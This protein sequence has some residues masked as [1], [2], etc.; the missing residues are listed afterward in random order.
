MNW[1]VKR[2]HTA[3]PSATY[4]ELCDFLRCSGSTLTTTEAIVR[5]LQH[6]MEA[7]RATVSPLQGFQWRFR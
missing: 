7:Q 3:V 4:S 5:A 1:E 6:W 2:G